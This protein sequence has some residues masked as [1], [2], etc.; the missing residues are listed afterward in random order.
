[1]TENLFIL[2]LRGLGFSVAF[3]LKLPY[4]KQQEFVQPLC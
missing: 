2:D 1:M 3:V 4:L